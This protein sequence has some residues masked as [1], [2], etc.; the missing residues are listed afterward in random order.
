MSGTTTGGPPAPPPPLP[1]LRA[2]LVLREAPD[3]SDGSKAWL[4]ADPLCQRFL[5]LG[6]DAFRLLSVWHPGP[7]SNVAA[8]HQARFGTAPHEA[9]IAAMAAILEKNELIEPVRGSWKASAGRLAASKRSLGAQIL[10]GYLFFRIPLMRPQAFLDAAWPFV[11]PLFTVGF[12]WFALLT[13]LL[14][15]WLAS[16]QWDV[17]VTTFMDFLSWEGALTYGASLILIKSLH[18]LGHAFQAR[19]LGVH[20]PTIGIAFMVL[21]PVLYTDTTDG[22]RKSRRDRLMID[23]G[24]IMVELVLAAFAT[25]AWALLEDGPLRSACFAAATVSWV[26]SLAVNLNPLMRFDGYYLLSDALDVENLQ[27]RGFAQARWRMRELLFGFGD[28]PPERLSATLGWTLTLHA[29]ATWIYRFFL[30]LGIAVL[31]YHVT[32]K[33]L[34]ILLFIVEIVFFVLKPVWREIGEWWKR[35]ADMRMNRQTLRTGLGLVLMGGVFLIPWQTSIHLPAVLRASQ[36]VPLHAPSE[37]MLAEILVRNGDRVKE[38][39]LL[40]RLSSPHLPMQ[41]AA[42]ASRRDL[43]L[44][45]LARMAADDRDRSERPVI[46]NESRSAGTMLQTLAAVEAALDIRATT[47]GTIANADPALHA[48]LW[49]SPSLRLAIIAADGVPSVIALAGEDGASR[50][51]TGA[52]GHFIPAEPEMVRIP[53]SLTAIADNPVTELPD[54]ILASDF[55][56]SVNVKHNRSGNMEPVATWYAASFR[57]A[58]DA[59]APRT[60]VAGTVILDGQAR[61]LAGRFLRRALSIMIRESGF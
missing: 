28:A 7:P 32:V 48:G 33:M 9:D 34:G 57:I 17:F 11:R 36:V 35:C 20:V 29:W 5:R 19:R 43:A 56:G 4:I 22:W 60:E 55:G 30:F 58:D 52:A 37:A 8:R 50:L 51:K 18:E 24:G 12:A 49:V 16:R 42:A 38:G 41:K 25:L 23:A 59:R 46:E 45:R 6:E 15:L 44:L 40:Y 2:G 3:R 1:A 53:V 14:G 27:E 10:H 13:G 61:S 31:V 47:D 39:Q 54:S 26:M 21:M